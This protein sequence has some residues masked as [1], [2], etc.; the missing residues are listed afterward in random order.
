MP[1]DLKGISPE[2]WGALQLM[3]WQ[4]RN[5]RKVTWLGFYAAGSGKGELPIHSLK[6]QSIEDSERRVA[7]AHLMLAAPQLYRAL[8]LA[9][10][11]LPPKLQ[12]Q[13]QTALSAARGE[14]GAKNVPLMG[15]VYDLV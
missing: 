3:R 8:A 1:D 12:A 5:A 6:P 7:D 9:L 13:A 15:T 2:P 14:G 4:G 10:P 11:H